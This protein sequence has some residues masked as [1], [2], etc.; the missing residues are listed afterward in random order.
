MYDIS[1]I[2]FSFSIVTS[3]SFSSFFDVTWIRIIHLD[4]DTTMDLCIR[5]A[6]LSRPAHA[7]DF[8]LL[9]EE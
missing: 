6:Q 8:H 5:Q 1:I 9:T 4:G 7:G 3:S 2:I